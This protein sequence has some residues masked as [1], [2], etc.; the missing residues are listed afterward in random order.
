MKTPTEWPQKI[1]E[2]YDPIRILGKGGFASV[3]LARQKHGK[4]TNTSK[5]KVAVKVVGCNSGSSTDYDGAEVTK[6]E[7]DQAVLYARREIEILQELSHPNIVQLFHHWIDNDATDDEESK[8]SKKPTVTAAVLI[9]EYAQG[10]TVDA[11]LKHGGALS[12]NFGRVVIAQTIDALAYLHYRAVLHRDIKPDNILVTGAMSSDDFIWDNNDEIPNWAALKAKY[13]VTLVDFGFARALTP[14]DVAS[15]SDET[16][17]RDSERASYHKLLKVET[18]DRGDVLGSSNRSNR[19][20]GTSISFRKRVSMALDGSRHSLLDWS[21]R[22][23][24]ELSS[25]N[26]SA[27]HKIKR[28]M[29]T[30]GNRNFAAPEIINKV[31]LESQHKNGENETTRKIVANAADAQPITETIS[32]YV[33]DYGLLVDSYSLGQ[34]IK[35]MMT[36]VTPGLSILQSFREQQRRDK[37]R[38]VFSMCVGEKKQ[39]RSVRVRRLEDSPGQMYTLI[40]ALTEISEQSRISIRKARRLPMISKVL[41]VSDAPT[42]PGG[43]LLESSPVSEDPESYKSSLAKITYLPFA[44]RDNAVHKVE[45]TTTSKIHPNSNRPCTIKIEEKDDGCVPLGA[46]GDIETSETLMF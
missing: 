38:K 1:Q 11:L 25:S 35:Y 45:P 33:A 21:G 23:S 2:S 28:T 18:N 6:A 12:S 20:S 39:K 34:A 17:R 4:E 32:N 14:G 41:W 8:K 31:R 3:V 36:G 44:D 24:D 26:R 16:V 19:S 13:K 22:S 40:M 30:L 42:G 10:P 15:P 46:K 9:L 37:I 43:E 5:T 27:T 29:S 7:R